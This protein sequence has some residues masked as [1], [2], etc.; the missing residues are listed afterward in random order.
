MYKP[1]SPNA[2]SPS[3]CAIVRTE[4][5]FFFFVKSGL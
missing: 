2:M 4:K 1:A 5:G 3:A